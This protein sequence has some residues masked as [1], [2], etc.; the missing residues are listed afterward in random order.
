MLGFSYL[1][2]SHTFTYNCPVRAMLG[3]F[4]RNGVVQS[5]FVAITGSLWQLRWIY[6]VV[7]NVDLRTV[8][9]AMLNF[10][11]KFHRIPP[12]KSTTCSCALGM[13]EL[14]QPRN[15]A[16]DLWTLTAYYWIYMVLTGSMWCFI[17]KVAMYTP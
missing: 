10:A 11:C 8:V 14:K 9:H 1:C 16:S 3:N 13:R 17:W 2:C 12:L 7:L 4:S 6:Q 15:G 5:N